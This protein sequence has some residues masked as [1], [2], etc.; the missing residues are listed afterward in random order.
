VKAA[1]GTEERTW[2]G[3]SW[4]IQAR[5]ALRFGAVADAVRYV[6]KALVATQHFQTP[7]ADWRIHRTASEA[8]R[9]NGDA[10]TA[11]RHAEFAVAK[12]A[13]LAASLPTGHRLRATLDAGD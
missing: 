10:Q 6:E 8:Y 5:V 11:E 7:L 12:K 1:S 4:E 3:L 2:Q 9:L 13:A